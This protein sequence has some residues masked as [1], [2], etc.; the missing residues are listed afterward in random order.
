MKSILLVDDNELILKALKHFLDRADFNV[1]AVPNGKEAIEMLD[2]QKFNVVVTDL[3]MPFSNGLDVIKKVKED[4]AHVGTGIIVV[5][6]IGNEGT[7]V[8]AFR[9]G[10]DDYMTKPVIATDLLSRIKKLL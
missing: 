8:E 2:K 7:L 10:A 1:V 6:S 9:L 5:S 3:M 4:V